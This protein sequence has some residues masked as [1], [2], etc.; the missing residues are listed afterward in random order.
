[1]RR[2]VVQEGERG[3]GSARSQ[4]DIKQRDAAGHGAAR[5]ATP[6]GAPGH[7]EDE[8]AFLAVSL[9][10]R[11]LLLGEWLPRGS[12]PQVEAVAAATGDGKEG[13]LQGIE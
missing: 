4:G 6:I 1:M 11:Y 10:R 9:P 8:G 7:C 13:T 2:E 5:E 12:A 3:G